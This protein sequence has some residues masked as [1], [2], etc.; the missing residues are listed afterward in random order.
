MDPHYSVLLSDD[1]SK[2]GE[3]CEALSLRNNK[4]KNVSTLIIATVVPIV[5][6]LILVIGLLIYFYPKYV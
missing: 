1:N 5:V 4:S 6:V 3:E 2:V